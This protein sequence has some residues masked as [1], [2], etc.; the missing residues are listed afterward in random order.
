MREIAAGD[1]IAFSELY[2]QLHSLLHITCC[3]EHRS[4]EQIDEIL[5]SVWM[6][7]WTDPASFSSDGLSIASQLVNLTEQTIEE[8]TSVQFGLL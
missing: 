2:D 1:A 4:I 3:W 7:V 8:W 5:Y 6:T